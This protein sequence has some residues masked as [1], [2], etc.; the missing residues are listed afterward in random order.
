MLLTSL[1]G[2]ESQALEYI[3]AISQ[4]YGLDLQSLFKFSCD[5]RSDLNGNWIMGHTILQWIH[6]LLDSAPEC[7]AGRRV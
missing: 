3:S 6:L 4:Y 1:M 5:Q 2:N 7:A